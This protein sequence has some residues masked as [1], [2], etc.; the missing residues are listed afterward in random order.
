[1]ACLHELPEAEDERAQGVRDP[2]AALHLA[3]G[4]LALETLELVY[5]IIDPDRF[6]LLKSCDPVIASAGYK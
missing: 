1:M 4:L 5:H 2:F 6:F 3:D